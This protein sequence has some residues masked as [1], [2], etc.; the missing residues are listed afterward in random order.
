MLINKNKHELIMVNILRDIY[1]NIKIS[2]LLGFKGGTALYFL[3]NLDRFSVDLDFDLL[4][5]NEENKKIVFNE[6]EKIIKK[7]GEIKDSYIK[8]NTIFF[9]LSYGENNKGIK[10]EISTRKTKDQYEIKDFLGVSILI[11]KA[12]YMFTNKLVALLGR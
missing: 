10:I 6:I 4:K 5:I 2:S 11:C 1:N 3:Y 7:Y 8:L 12:E 9:M